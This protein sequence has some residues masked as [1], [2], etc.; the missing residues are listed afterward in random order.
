[1]IK[2]TGTSRG[3]SNNNV[4][5]LV[6]FLHGFGADAN[7]LIGLSEE[8][9][10]LFPKAVF[11]SPNAPFPCEDFPFGFQWFS[12]IDRRDE[13][14]YK[15]LSVAL[16]ILKNYVDENLKNY[17][18]NYKDLVLI[19]FSQGTMMAL[20]LALNLPEPCY[21]VIGFSG[22]LIGGGFLNK[23][24]LAK[25]P[26]F[27]SHGEQDG[28]LSLSLHQKMVDDLSKLE[29]PFVNH[30]IPGDGHT[31]SFRALELSKD[32]IGGLSK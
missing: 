8:F 16:P 29:V 32:F 22:I 6:I 20:Q 28:V 13:E 23:K 17:N 27:L 25:P 10:E 4:N 21:A 19:G 3:A 26:I 7:D 14:L 24:E 18:L 31:I 11:L 30:V 15:G 1:M 5:K 9:L 12:L 2:L